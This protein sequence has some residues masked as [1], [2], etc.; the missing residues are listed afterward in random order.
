MTIEQVEALDQASVANG[1]SGPPGG[2]RRLRATSSPRLGRAKGL[3]ARARAGPPLQ[4][5][6]AEAGRRRRRRE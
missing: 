3:P 6:V 4:A 5:Q 2:Q 1:T